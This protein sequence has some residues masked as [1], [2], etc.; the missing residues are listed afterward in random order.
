MKNYEK[1]ILKCVKNRNILDKLELLVQNE[2]SKM[3]IA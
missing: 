2:F 3:E 1:F